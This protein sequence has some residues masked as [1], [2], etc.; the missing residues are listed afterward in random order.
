MGDTSITIVDRALQF[1]ITTPAAVAELK[2]LDRD[3]DGKL[4]V[5]DQV[6]GG[7]GDRP[8]FIVDGDCVHGDSYGAEPRV[9]PENWFGVWLNKN[10]FRDKIVA[11]LATG[12]V[13]KN[14]AQEKSLRDLFGTYNAVAAVDRATSIMNDVPHSTGTFGGVLVYNPLYWDKIAPLIDPHT[15]GELSNLSELSTRIYKNLAGMVELD[16]TAYA[17]PRMD[18][19]A[20]CGNPILYG[21][22]IPADAVFAELQPVY[23]EMLARW[24]VSIKYLYQFGVAECDGDGCRPHNPMQ[25][26]DERIF[27]V[28]TIEWDVR[29]LQVSITDAKMCDSSF[30]PL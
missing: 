2:K 1:T 19:S 16:T 20:A 11:A 29:E 30:N 4:T 12:G 27:Q 17:L 3:G 5:D 14:H 23:Q 18:D 10:I 13:L 15:N 25:L 28:P 24:S 7:L 8:E 26:K 22:S 21:L 9:N 6:C